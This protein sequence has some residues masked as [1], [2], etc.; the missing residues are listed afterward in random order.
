MITVYAKHGQRIEIR[1][2]AAV[3]VTELPNK[4][5]NTPASAL[6]IIAATGETLAVFRVKEVSGYD[7]SAAGAGSRT[8]SSSRNA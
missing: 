1:N 6:A 4:E 2:G 5:G 3:V 8:A 7:L